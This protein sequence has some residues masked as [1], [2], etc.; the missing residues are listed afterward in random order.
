MNAEIALENSREALQIIQQAAT[1]T[2]GSREAEAY[3]K[4]RTGLNDAQFYSPAIRQ[5]IQEGGVDFYTEGWA[6]ITAYER[7][8]G[9]L[10]IQRLGQ[11]QELGEWII[12]PGNQIVG[13]NYDISYTNRNHLHLQST[14]HEISETLA[15]LKRHV[16]CS[17]R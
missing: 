7:A 12:H 5:I 6:L 2:I 8:A 4:D 1:T 15:E 10:I 9:T 14:L 17:T 11:G 13:Y 16:N 3:F